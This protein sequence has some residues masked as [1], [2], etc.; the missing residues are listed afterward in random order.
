LKSDNGSEYCSNDFDNYCSLNGIRRIKVTPITPQEN[1]FSERI[2]R[3]I[4][5]HARC[6][7]L[8]AG[9]P[10]FLWAYCIDTAVYL[11]NKGPSSALDGGIPK[12]LW[13]GKT[14]NYSFLRLLGCEAFAHIDKKKKIERS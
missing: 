9:L 8:H 4:L 11:I 3:K 2:N 5:E 13:S 12:E 1:G 7:R 14:C 6:L 10:L